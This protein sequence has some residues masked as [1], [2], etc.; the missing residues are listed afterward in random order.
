MLI[1]PRVTV[2][3][4]GRVIV[5]TCRF[6]SPLCSYMEWYLEIVR[7]SNLLLFGELIFID[8]E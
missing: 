4:I 2:S 8:D 3:L 5:D 6:W 7:E 1:L